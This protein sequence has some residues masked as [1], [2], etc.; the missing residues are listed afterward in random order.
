MSVKEN[1]SNPG[2]L[3]TQQYNTSDKLSARIRLHQNYSTT[4]ESPI[5]GTFDLMLEYLPENAKIL[6]V[7]TGRGDLWK[8][9]ASR[10]PEGWDMTLTDLSAGMIA[11]QKA[12]L[13]DLARVMNYEV[14]NAVDIPYADNSFDAV[15]ANYMLYH[16]PDR[17]KAIA[18]IRR[19]LKPDGTLFATTNG[20]NHMK[21]IFTI[22]R[23]VS[24]ITREETV[25]AETFSLQN[26]LAQLMQEFTDIRMIRFNNN[27]WIPEARPVLD[28]IASMS[29]IEGEAIIRQH[30]TAMREN[31][32]RMIVDK[33]G[34]F[35][36]KET[37]VF[38]ARGVY[39]NT[40]TSSN[41]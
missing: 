36:E 40:E 29:S 8:E 17:V 15:V 1:F 21:L 22:A 4:D 27:L 13:G 25:V 10:I 16:V 41:N 23:D 35:I 7:G 39:D 31:L 26:G 6:E 20:A 30:E 38:I 3:K 18:E 24:E 34:I 12:Y 5:S 37:G 28:Y 9:N 32:N 11:D 14:V 19:V 33:G 2:Y